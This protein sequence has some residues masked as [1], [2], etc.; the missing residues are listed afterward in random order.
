MITRTTYRI[1]GPGS[2]GHMHYLPDFSLPATLRDGS[3]HH[4]LTSEEAEAQR[5]NVSA[6]D[7]RAPGQ[8][9][10]LPPLLPVL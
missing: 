1:C 7:H 6:K 4:S 9:N 5:C 10:V 3:N 2:T 8:Q